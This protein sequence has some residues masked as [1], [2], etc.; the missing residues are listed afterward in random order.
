MR[1]EVTADAANARSFLVRIEGE[2]RRPRELHAALGRRLARE[3]QGHFRARNREPNRMDAPKTNFWAQVAAATA[4]S[5]VSETEAIVTVAEARF[6]IHLFGGP[7]RPTGGRKFLTIPIVKEA[8]GRRV[9]DYEKYTGRKL[10]RLPGTGVLVER[11]ARQADR[12]SLGPARGVIRGRE[13]FRPVGVRG[14]SPL[15][16]VYVLKRQ[17]IIPRDPR[18]LPQPETLVSALQDT[19]NAWLARQGNGGAA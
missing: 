1:I 14:R 16:V 8:R 4:L 12:S 5:T 9:E 15:R 13:G 11:N 17:V 7:I 18:A 10:F 19:A 2:I 6:R 3:L